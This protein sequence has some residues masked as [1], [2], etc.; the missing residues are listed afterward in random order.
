MDI[1]GKEGSECKGPEAGAWLVTSQN[2]R[3][4]LWLP[5]VGQAERS[6]GGS[7]GQGLVVLALLVLA[8]SKEMGGAKAWVEQRNELT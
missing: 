8:P 1:P 3:K 7:R 5:F 4:L 6:G 2:N